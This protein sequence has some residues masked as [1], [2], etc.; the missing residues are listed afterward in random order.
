M[1]T[2]K[3]EGTP[4]PGKYYWK[5]NTSLL[6]HTLVKHRFIELWGN[7]K[8]KIDSYQSINEWWENFVKLKIKTFFINEG[9]IANKKMYGFIFQMVTS[10]MK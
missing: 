2:L 9:K 8:R 5:L 4:V 1:T 3:I 7:L 6:E 10:I